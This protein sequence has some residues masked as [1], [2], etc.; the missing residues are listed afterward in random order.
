M[1]L[2][3]LL[4]IVSFSLTAT[5]SPDLKERRQKLRKEM[6]DGVLVL[7]GNLESEDVHYDFF[8]EPNFLYL[9]GWEEPGAILVMTPEPEKDEP[10]IA[11]RARVAREILFVPQRVP[12]VEKWTGRKLGPSDPKVR[13]TTGIQTVMPSEQFETELAKLLAIYPNL[14]VLKSATTTESLAKLAPMRT[15]S[16]IRN[17]IEKLR[18]KKS[19]TE[20]AAIQRATDASIDAHR[21]AWRNIAPGKYEYQIAAVMVSTYMGEGCRRSVFIT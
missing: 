11:E 3:L 15:I 21:A 6:A 4:L 9:T 16:D 5:V 8:Q 2:S 10:D 13:N 12:N 14:Y 19:Q 7:F 20:I 17:G 1:R 18:M